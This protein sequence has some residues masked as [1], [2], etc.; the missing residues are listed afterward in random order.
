M[1]FLRFSR[2]KRGYENTYLCHTF[3]SGGKVGLR[4]LYWFR[5]PPEV[6]VGRLALDPEAIRAIEESNPD[7][8]FDWGK[9]L[10]VKPPPPPPDYGRD[11][12]DV[13]RTRRR[14]GRD[15]SAD[16][17]ATSPEASSA[18]EQAGTAELVPADKT[19]AASE[20]G[21][22]HLVLA[23]TDEQ[24]LARLRARHA[25][26]Q[27][28]ISDKVRDPAKLEELRAQA[29]LLDPDA[30]STLE[31]ARE[32]LASLDEATD[33]IRKVLGRRRRTRRRGAGRS[34]LPRAGAAEGT[35]SPEGGADDVPD[36]GEGAEASASSVELASDPS[37]E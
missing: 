10:K 26:I 25:E 27:A 1:P 35:A 21:E 23:L 30:W 9:I 11:G 6:K 12:R 33:A 20:Q 36:G 28:R 19:G 16:S 29:A 17:D 7:L 8:Q 22:G 3:R 18:T 13:R 34:R 4:V 15:A 37:E 14:R 31:E 2:D 32:R 24:G 5:T